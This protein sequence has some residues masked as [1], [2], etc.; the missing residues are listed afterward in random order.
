MPQPIL[1]DTDPGIDDAMALMYALA[2]D[3]LEVV[4]VTSVFGNATVDATTRNAIDLLDIAGRPD[5]PV[6]R[7]AARPLATPYRGVPDFVHGPAGRGDLSPATPR[8]AEGPLSAPQLIIDR[9]RSH[10]GDLR[11]VALGPLT[12]VAMA[13]I[14]EPELDLQIAELIIMGGNAF[15]SGNATPAAEA[16]FFNDPD[17]ADVV[18]GARCPIVMVGLDVTESIVLDA[19]ELADLGNTDNPRTRHL[20]ALVPT[21]LDF[22]RRHYGIDGIFVHDSTTITYLLAPQLFTEVSCAVRVDCGH[23]AARGATIASL[24]RSEPDSASDDRPP[25]TVLTD[26][27]ARAATT[28]ELQ[29]HRRP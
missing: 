8:R 14:L 1:I 25:V 9:V 29:H 17:A 4:A 5:I 27:D 2:A 18:L 21:Y 16:N 26:V 3:D 20:S 19:T 24:G 28:L 13:L 22:H 12:N 6:G 11:V 15:T 10:G 7:G 23:G